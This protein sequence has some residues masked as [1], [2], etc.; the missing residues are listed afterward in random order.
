MAS[1]EK[2]TKWVREKKPA[3]I[4][5]SL[6]NKSIGHIRFICGL[7]QLQVREGRWFAH[8]QL[9]DSVAWEMK[10]VVGL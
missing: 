1:R 4:V 5:G 10:D 6:Q 3:V 9:E 7:Y 8:K 2:I